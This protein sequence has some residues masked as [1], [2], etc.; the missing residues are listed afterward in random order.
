MKTLILVR[1][2]K[3]SWT[4]PSL[5]D[6]D[7]PLN[8]RGRR[9][10]PFMGKVLA[11][12][13]IKPDAILSSSAVRAFETAKFFAGALGWEPASIAVRPEIYHADSEAMLELI[14]GLDDAAETVLIFGHNPIFTY[15]A[16]LFTDR[17]LDNL[18]T[19]GIFAVEFAVEHWSE[20]RPRAGKFLFQEFPRTYFPKDALD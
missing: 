3:S 5:S 13:G 8:E 18:P 7:R 14:A 15:L 20:A 12:R 1:H 9:D 2:A 6:H 16:N 11:D 4:D 10:A 17:Y 19:C